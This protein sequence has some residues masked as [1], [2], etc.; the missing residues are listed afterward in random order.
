MRLL[1]RKII[2][3]I[4]IRPINLSKLWLLSTTISSIAIIT[5]Y[6]NHIYKLSLFNLSSFITL[7]WAKSTKLYKHSSLW[8]FQKFNLQFNKLELFSLISHKK[9][10][11]SQVYK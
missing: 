5:T 9:A 10:N 6:V 4:L 3:T 11:N 7:F 1:E 8:N 2:R